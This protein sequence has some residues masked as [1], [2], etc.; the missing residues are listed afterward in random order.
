MIEFFFGL[1]SFSWITGIFNTLAWALIV[2]GITL[3]VILL[4][5]SR[6]LPTALSQY[7]IMGQL[8]GLILCVFFVFQAGRHNEY[9][10]QQVVLQEERIKRAELEL[11]SMAI[12][13]DVEIQYQDK[14]KYIVKWK[15]IPVT[16]YIPV[17]ADKICKID[18]IAPNFRKLIDAAAAGKE[19]PKDLK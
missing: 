11:Q 16:K 3:G 18:E 13:N 9:N 6:F 5:G 17:E 8:L 1:F 19:L 10:T 12:T 14:I 15:E 4:I 2:P 7:K